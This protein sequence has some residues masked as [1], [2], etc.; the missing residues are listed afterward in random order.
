MRNGLPA[1]GKEGKGK[2]SLPISGSKLQI[3]RSGP[4]ETNFAVVDLPGLVRGE[5]HVT[6]VEQG[7][8]V[9]RERSK[10]G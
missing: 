9:G 1:S 10:K 3:M 2:S 6:V 7:G 8:E 4:K 5:L